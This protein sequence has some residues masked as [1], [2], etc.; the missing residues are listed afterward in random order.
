[1]KKIVAGLFMTLDGVAE[2]P[3]SWQFPYFN[4]QMMK[5]LGAGMASADTLLLGRRTYEMYASYF[6][7]S[8]EDLA[9]YMNNTPKYVV[10]T[11]LKKLDW[12]NS[13][14]INGDLAE[15]INKLKQLPGSNISLSGSP[16]L[17]R[18]LLR[19][20]LLDELWLLVH[21]VLVGQGARLFSEDSDGQVPLKLVN[22]E[23]FDTGVLSLTYEPAK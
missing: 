8:E 1:M 19:E 15:E 10:S 13:T 14:L 7:T 4:D 12:Q 23:T 9:A 18:S 6:P 2:S 20:G 11:T 3:Q 16:T 22:S 21:P 5:A 17:V